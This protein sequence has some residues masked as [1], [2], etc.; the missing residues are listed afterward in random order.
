MD[1]VGEC[2]G[3]YSRNGQRNVLAIRYEIIE[4][5]LR[6]VQQRR[7]GDEADGHALLLARRC[8]FENAR[9]EVMTEEER[10]E[11]I[12]LLLLRTGWSEAVFLKLSDQELQ[13][14]YDERVQGE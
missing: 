1:P 8:V 2:A 13:R 12:A 4:R 7:L 11:K 3:F 10:E 5:D 14:L 6:Q 9:G